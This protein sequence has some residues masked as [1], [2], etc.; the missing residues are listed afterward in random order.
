[1]DKPENSYDVPIFELQPC[2]LKPQ[3][4]PDVIDV[5]Q[6]SKKT[7]EKSH[8]KTFLLFFALLVLILLIQVALLVLTLLEKKDVDS[9]AANF[10][11]NK[12]CK[13]CNGTFLN[14]T[15]FDDQQLYFDKRL[16]LSTELIVEKLSSYN[17]E[18]NS[19]ATSVMDIM[20]NL[21]N[22]QLLGLQNSTEFLKST[23]VSA[24]SQELAS[25]FTSLLNLKNGINS[26]AGVIDDVLILVKNLLELHNETS[27]LATSI[28]K[29]MLETALKVEE[30]FN[31]NS[32]QLLGLQNSTELLKNTIISS[33]SQEFARVFAS[34]S[35]LENGIDSSAG[36]ID[37]VLILVKNLLELHN[38][39]S[40]FW[41]SS[42]K[43]INNKYPNSPSGYYIIGNGSVYC[44]MGTLCNSTGGWARLAYL[45]M[46]LPTQNCPPGFQMY[47]TGGVRACGRVNTNTDCLPVIFPSNNISYS[48]IC[49][50]VVGYQHAS[51]DAIDPRFGDHNDINGH[52]V[53]GISI[54]RGSPRQHVWTLM[55]GLQDEGTNNRNLNC[56]CAAGATVPVQ[57]FIGEHYFCESGNSN[58]YAWRYNTLYVE[59]PLWDGQDCG[60]RELACCAAPGLP[61]F[62]RNYTSTTDDFLELR[63]CLDQI[64]SD[65][66]AAVG[67]Y[68]IYVK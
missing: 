30:I 64:V 40:Y 13:K 63:L 55:S 59:D 41:P 5:Q 33:K 39:T 52:Y 25:I 56:P 11:D 42:C 46:S 8:R 19:L 23:I 2:D 66:D 32:E 35:N 57:S 9:T 18:T 6:Q 60:S 12:R 14:Y 17:L 24:K 37:D 61:W 29:I 21:S 53:D 58:S 38:E 10:L 36:V 54:T 48:E 16:N 34:L 45:D 62:Y 51:T 20:N 49:G 27:S 67:F 15:I 22:E 7:T 28:M 44:H 68:E 3:S 65:E 50:R 4:Q 47:N 26:S 31:L 1:M 43:Q